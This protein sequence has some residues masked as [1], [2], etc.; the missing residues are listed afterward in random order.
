MFVIVK[1]FYFSFLLG[2]LMAMITVKV[3]L[4]VVREHDPLGRD[5]EVFRQHLFAAGKEGP[6]VKGSMGAELADGLV[7]KEGD[8][9][10]VKT[11]FSAFFA[12]HLHSF[13]QGAG[14]TNL[15]IT[16]QCTFQSGEPFLI[17]LQCCVFQVVFI[18]FQYIGSLSVGVQ[19]PNCIRQT[20]FDAVALDYQPVTVIVDATAAATPDIH[21]GTYFLLLERNAGLQLW[22][23]K[24]QRDKACFGWIY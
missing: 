5:V 12:T 21:T 13:L 2:A 20:V 9:K 22:F 18:A 24:L 15:V 23:L 1:Y 6:T 16:G 17:V 7:I 11:R 3:G 8:Y 4:Q 10:L 19:T 14:I